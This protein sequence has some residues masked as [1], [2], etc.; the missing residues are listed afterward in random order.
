MD[1]DA[2]FAVFCFL[3]ACGALAGAVVG[4]VMAALNLLRR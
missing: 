3:L 1:T 4:I 2:F